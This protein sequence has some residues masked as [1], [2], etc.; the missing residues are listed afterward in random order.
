MLGLH[1]APAR[2]RSKVVV[3]KRHLQL[4]GRGRKVAL[5][6]K[7]Y[8]W[9]LVAALSALLL[10]VLSAFAI[11]QSD[12]ATTTLCLRLLILV[13]LLAPQFYV[14]YAGTTGDFPGAVRPCRAG[15]LLDLMQSGVVLL[16]VSMVFP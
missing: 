4:S 1:I 16:A 15:W 6:E 12:S 10:S 13:L 8:D 9:F 3:L 5:P 14:E 7:H 11:S 2:D